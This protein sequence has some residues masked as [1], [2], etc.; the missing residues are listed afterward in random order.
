MKEQ[1]QQADRELMQAGA[2]LD[3]MGVADFESHRPDRPI[4]DQALVWSAAGMILEKVYSASD[5]VQ[6]VISDLPDEDQ[7]SPQTD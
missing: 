2:L 3:L 1:L 6:A 7:E 4:I 5:K